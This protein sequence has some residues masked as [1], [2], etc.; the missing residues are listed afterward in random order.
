MIRI[1]LLPPETRRAASGQRVSVPLRP[2]GVGAG[3]FV[4]VLTL[5]LVA[6]NAWNAG[7]LARLKQEWEQ[8]RP[9]KAQLER[10]QSQ[11]QLLQGQAGVLEQVKA[12]RGRWAPRLNLLSD[13]VVSQVWFTRLTVEPGQPVFLKG[14]ALVAGAGE[15][16]AAVTKFLQRL[17]EQ[18]A[19]QDWFKGVDLQ[20]VA[21][22]QIGQEEVVDFSI[23]LLPTG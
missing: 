1:N 22:R 11:L 13:A 16:G 2:L 18:P 6:G 3:G 17:K 15:S 8:M 20:S 19:F 4:A 21:H 14:S 7:R 9:K 12:P 10:E 5:V 23:L